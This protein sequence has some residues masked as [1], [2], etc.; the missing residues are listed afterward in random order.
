MRRQARARCGSGERRASRRILLTGLS[1]YWGGRLAQALE[2]DPRGRGDHRHR[3][4]AAEGRAGAHGVRPGHRPAL[5][6]PPHRPGR[7]DRHR[8]RHAPGRGLDRHRAA[9]G[10]REQRHRDDERPGGLRR[11]RTRRCARS[12]S[13]P[14]PTTT[15]ASRTT[16]R[17]SPRRCGARTAPGTPIERDIVEAEARGRRS[18]P[19]ATRR[20][21]SPSCASPTASG[22]TIRTSHTRLFQ[23]PVVPTI[24]GFDP[25]C[26][27]IHED[28]IA[29]CLE[30]A[31][32]HDLDGVFNCAADGVLALSEV[33]SLLGKTNAADPAA[34]GDGLGARRALRRTGADI[35]VEM[36]Q[37]AALRPGR[38]TTAATRRRASATATRRARPSSSCASISAWRR[39]WRATAER[40]PL[41]G[42]GRG[43][44]APQP[45]RAPAVRGAAS[46]RGPA[47]RRRRGE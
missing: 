45:Q 14:A 1:T 22:R 26:Q 17:S 13:S 23:L 28:D 19:S 46:P 9:A 6:D 27:F 15:A 31:V 30:H 36:L 3:Q 8:G 33:I 35:P 32:L 47:P 2:Q 5:A 11:A 25:R 4:A 24:L 12:S 40:L 34:G 39:C 10:P 7:R 20:R 21:R 43:V 41:R 37:S 29:N 38:W 18:S 42:G 44:P 16:R